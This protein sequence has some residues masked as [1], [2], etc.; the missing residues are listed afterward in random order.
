MTQEQDPW[1]EKNKNINYEQ[2]HELCA[3]ITWGVLRSVSE[4]MGLHLCI[5]QVILDSYCG[6]FHNDMI[7]YEL[8]HVL[9]EYALCQWGINMNMNINVGYSYGFLMSFAW[10]EWVYGTSLAH[11]IRRSKKGYVVLSLWYE[12]MCIHVCM[13]WIVTMNDVTYEHESLFF[14]RYGLTMFS[15]NVHDGF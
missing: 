13:I 11:Y 8:I 6:M 1:H 3:I 12:V 15:Q 9:H 7:L 4:G 5:A 10:C 2:E 14:L